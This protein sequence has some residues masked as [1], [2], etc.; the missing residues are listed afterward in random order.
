MTA[1]PP[2]ET[3]VDLLRGELPADSAPAMRGHVE[4]CPSCL[5]ALDRLSDDAD[6]AAWIE[7]GLGEDGGRTVRAAVAGTAAVGDGQPRAIGGYEIEAEIGRGG[8]GVV[9]RARER[10]TGRAVALKVLRPDLD[11]DRARRRFVREVR[12]AAAVEHDH[13][14]RVYATSDPAEALLFFAM[15]LV[16]GPS[17]AERIRADG[18]LEARGAAKLVVQAADGLAAAH[19]AGLVHR[20]VKPE[21]V[22]IDTATGRAKVGD[23]GLARLA[24]ESSDLTRS[25]V[26]AGTPAYLS[27]EQARGD[28]GAG[29]LV[30]VYGLGVTLYECLTGEAPFGGT[31]HMVV[32]QILQDDPRPPRRLNDAVPRDLET[33]CLTAMAREPHRRYASA[34][35]MADD[36]RRWLRGEPIRARAVSAAERGWRLARR[37]PLTATLA[38]A[39][40]IAL[41]AGTTTSVVLW[42]RAEAHLRAAARDYRRARDAVDKLYVRLYTGTLL[43]RPGLETVRTEITRDAVAYYREFLRDHG[44]D[45]ALR[46]DAARASFAAGKLLFDTGDRREALDFLRQAGP[47][48]EELGRTNLERRFEAA[49]CHDLVAVL[50]A[51]LGREPEALAAHGRAVEAYRALAA[52]DPGNARWQRMVGHALGNLANTHVKAG[53][54]REARAIFAQARK[55]FEALLASAPPHPFYRQDLALTLHNMALVADSAEGP[56]LF[57][58]ALAIREA[59]A[60]AEPGNA[61]ARR[62][63]ARTRQKQASFL[64]VDGRVAEALPPLIAASD[65]L[66]KLVRD[67]PDRIDYALDMGEACNDRAAV[68][69][70]LGR[71]ADALAASDEALGLLTRIAGVDPENVLVRQFLAGAYDLAARS[72][73]ALSHP[74][75][76]LRA[77]RA[78]VPVL[79]HLARTRPGDPEVK[80][81]LAEH[82]KAIAA[83]EARANGPQ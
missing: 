8:M 66:R 35:A 10:T 70:A 69:L 71:P 29:P 72:H 31:P 1:C 34:A 13:I 53:R 6:L 19:D 14:V 21:N 17:L 2:R 65:E 73:D 62:N 22:L 51:D 78:A 40:A 9:Y 82:R 77:R 30:D 59:L 39:L 60:A 24:A 25:G 37:R 5:A 49:R 38:A 63:V 52:A 23:F 28:D 55:Q 32:Q 41:V 81:A 58:E 75:E 12:A 11:D 74:D 43:D 26:V 80:Q 36:L 15:E 44:D 4:A 54:A 83:A 16:A 56:A 27:P 47:L 50:A 46:A 33:I 57:R 64:R 42:R 67:H 20:D 45:P 79:E 3:L 18:R 7:A 76:A 68:L 61:Y 48:L